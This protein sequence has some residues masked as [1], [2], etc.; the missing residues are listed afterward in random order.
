M[1]EEEGVLLDYRDG[2]GEGYGL[3]LGLTRRRG[4]HIPKHT[5]PPLSSFAILQ[6]QTTPTMK[7]SK[8]LLALALAA[9]SVHAAAPPGINPGPDPVH[10]P[11]PAPSTRTKDAQNP[12]VPPKA[13]WPDPDTGPSPV[14]VVADARLTHQ[15]LARSSALKQAAKQSQP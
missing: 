4:M 7:L 10:A 11:Q 13:I 15:S 3:L 14:P 12:P 6:V 8:P 9:S 1:F 2:I 5:R